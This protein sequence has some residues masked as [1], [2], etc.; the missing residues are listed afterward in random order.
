[1]ALSAQTGDIAP[2][3]D[4]NYVLKCSQGIRVPQKPSQTTGFEIF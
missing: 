4:P 2:L 3:I 1:M